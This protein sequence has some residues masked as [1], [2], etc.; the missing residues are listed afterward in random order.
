VVPLNDG[1]AI[2]ARDITERKLLEE[3]MRQ[4]NSFLQ[5]MIDHLPVAVFVKDGKDNR[6][7]EF[8]LWNRTSEMMFGLTSQQAIGKTVHD[9]FPK[10]QADFFGKKDRQAFERGTPED[11]PE[12]PIDSYSL[13]RRI[14]HT[15]KVPL[16]DENHE[17]E[18][19]L[20]ISEDITDRK[21]AEAELLHKSQA[22]G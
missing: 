5:T 9:L 7:G 6:F 12:E 14:L 2:T 1:V 3:E 17:P 18:Y 15:V 19:L 4:T 11:I 16:Y 22:L 8:K 13:G 10:E 20:C 21:Q